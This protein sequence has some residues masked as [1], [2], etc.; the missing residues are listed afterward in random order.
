MEA[1]IWSSGVVHGHAGKSPADLEMHS[2]DALYRQERGPIGQLLL[3]PYRAFSQLRQT[4]YASAVALTFAAVCLDSALVSDLNT[5]APAFSCGLLLLLMLR[6]LPAEAPS[7]QST[8]L[9]TG[10][11]L[12]TWRL[13]C[14]F[15]LHLSVIGAGL[16][17]G[18]VWRGPV[19]YTHLTLPTICSV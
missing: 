13:F 2:S 15:A 4:E 7:I 19:S 1:L 3:A 16:A 18:G 12:A 14:F 11:P 10:P 9:Q 6:R 5:I 17:M 8:Q